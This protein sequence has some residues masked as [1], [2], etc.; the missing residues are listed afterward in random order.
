MSAVAQAVDARPIGRAISEPDIDADG[1]ALAWALG[2]VAGPADHTDTQIL[3]ACHVVEASELTGAE[4][5][6][7]AAEL[8]GMIEGLPA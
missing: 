7:A 4:Q 3:V 6:H 2:V 5:R 8:R 1:A